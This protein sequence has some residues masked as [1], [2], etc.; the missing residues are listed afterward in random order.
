MAHGVLARLG[1]RGTT[2]HRRRPSAR[3]ALNALCARSDSVHV[4]VASSARSPAG[5]V[6]ALAER[7]GAQIDSR[8]R[9]AIIFVRE[10]VLE[11][12]PRH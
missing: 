12:R 1:H 9:V 7:L 5:G 6:G 10:Q 4:G 2:L 3:R 11:I 8:T